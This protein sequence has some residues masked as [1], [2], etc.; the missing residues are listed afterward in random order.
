MKD[1]IEYSKMHKVF[2]IFLIGDCVY[3]NDID[4]TPISYHG[5]LFNWA[6]YDYNDLYIYF[7]NV[8]NT[9]PNNLSYKMIVP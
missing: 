9:N 7:E 5:F 6:T 4:V 8:V 3:F 2:A 1:F